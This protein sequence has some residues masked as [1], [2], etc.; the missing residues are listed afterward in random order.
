VFVKPS[1]KADPAFSES[2]PETP[3]PVAARQLL[4][5]REHSLYQDLTAL[6]PDHKVF[7]QVALSQIIDVPEDHPERIAI[8]NRFTQLVAD[9]VLCRQDMSIVA[10]IELDD[11]SHHR[12]DRQYADARKTKALVDAG[13]KLVRIPAGPLPIQQ[14]LRALIGAEQHPLEQ[15]VPGETELRLAETVA[16]HAPKAST[17]EQGPFGSGMSR[18]MRRALWRSGVTVIFA[19]AGLAMYTTFL[20]SVVRRAFEP[21]VSR[22]IAPTVARSHPAA[23][24]I[25]PASAFE[26]IA[27]PP[28]AQALAES[29][30]AEVQAAADLQ[31]Q[32]N[33]AWPAFYSAPAS[34]EHP[35]SWN[36]QVECGNKYMRAKKLFEQQWATEHPSAPVQE[37]TVLDNASLGRTRK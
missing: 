18:K 3:W 8:R 32:K 26:P 31:K 16:I 20:P 10:V 21:L 19:A 5:N 17:T 11:G 23:P 24:L 25:F 2:L 37:A 6:Y 12:R 4:S 1:V 27:V 33:R 14:K 22:P 15:V 35:A 7:V 13:V 9:F 28:T 34:C 29:R 30:R 36:D